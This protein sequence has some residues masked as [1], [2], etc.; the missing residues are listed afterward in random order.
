MHI[1]I[2]CIGDLSKIYTARFLS[3]LKTTLII[4]SYYVSDLYHQIMSIL[5]LRIIFND[6]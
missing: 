5:E 4:T 6:K 1:Y 3:K 2:V